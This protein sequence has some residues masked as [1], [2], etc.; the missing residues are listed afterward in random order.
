MKIK[1]LISCLCLVAFNAHAAVLEKAVEAIKI[2][3]TKKPTSRPMTMA[4]EPN[5]KRYYLAD[6]G[7]G[8]IQDGNSISTSKSEI[9]A[10]DLKGNYINSTQE[11][12]DNRALYFNPNT[13]L[14][15]TATYNIS[16]GAGFSPDTGIFAL[17]LNK[18]GNL[19]K[20]RLEII[21]FNP[22][23]GDP[24]TM[25][26]YDPAEQRYFAKQGRSDK[27]FIVKLEKREPFAEITL[28]LAA[29]KVQFDDISDHYIAYTA[30]SG[31][32]LAV[33]DVD[34]K[35]VLVFNLTGKFV[36]KCALPN[37]MKLRS[38]N[39]LNGLGYANGMMFVYHEPEGEFGVYYGFKVSDQA[40]SQ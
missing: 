15:E 16:S 9:H 6:G 20:Q 10:F 13:N 8:P 31:E 36:G 5:Y 34:H 21:N 25:P 3:L 29:A 35:A 26:S 32:E 40:V 22:A 30:I 19:T 24:N 7:L 11:G 38:Q 12:L 27:V 28:D 23:F 2:P 18:E 4:Y 33:L 17:E 37:T 39:H 1:V 14:L